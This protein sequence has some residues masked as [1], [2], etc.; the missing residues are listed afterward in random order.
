MKNKKIIGWGSSPIFELYLRN[1]SEHQV[2]YCVDISKK[3][4]DN[5]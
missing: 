4:G 2:E 1:S 3:T 5:S